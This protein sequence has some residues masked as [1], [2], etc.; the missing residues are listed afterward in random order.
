MLKYIP[1]IA[2]ASLASVFLESGVNKIL[3]PVVTQQFMAAYGIPFTRFFLVSAIVLELTAGLSVLLGYKARWGAIALIKFLITVTF[4]FHT[5]FSDHMQ[6][7]H[8]MKNLAILGGLMMVV[9][10]GS[11]AVSFDRRSILANSKRQIVRY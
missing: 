10:Y 6:V 2:R 3:H 8:F 5:N 9:Q 4:I 11:G 7:G 1:L